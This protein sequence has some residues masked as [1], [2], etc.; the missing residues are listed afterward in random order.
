VASKGFRFYWKPLQKGLITISPVRRIDEDWVYGAT[1]GDCYAITNVFSTGSSSQ[2]TGGLAG[3]VESDSVVS[4][5]YAAGSVQAISIGG[6]EPFYTGGLEGEV[7][8]SEISDSYALGNVLADKTA[9]ISPFYAGGLVGSFL[10]IAGKTIERCFSAGTVRSQS[11]EANGTIYAGG[12]VSHNNS[13]NLT[14]NAALGDSVTAIGGSSRTAAR[15]YVFSNGANSANYAVDSMRIES[16]SSYNAIYIA[17]AYETGSNGTSQHG[18]TAN[19]STFR[20]PAFWT[21]TLGFS[22]A[23]W[24]FGSVVSR[25]HPALAGLGGQ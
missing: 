13:G 20:N 19:G 16:S 5:C 11:S 3:S 1:F 2:Y 7:D 4:R 15:V 24:N 17:P 25:G 9:G 12:I 22:S 18:A 14:H 10:G 23:E 6:G 8:D 21:T